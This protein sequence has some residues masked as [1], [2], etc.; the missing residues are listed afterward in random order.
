MINMKL[1]K[2]EKIYRNAAPYRLPETAKQPALGSVYVVMSKSVEDTL[3][4]LAQPMFKHRYLTSYYHEKLYN[5]KIFN[6]LIRHRHKDLELSQKFE[7][8]YAGILPGL[9]IKLNRAQLRAR[10]YIEDISEFNSTF[11]NHK[12]S[13]I[14]IQVVNEYF[15]LFE[16]LVIKR[17]E[18][19]YVNKVL[20][21]PVNQ[22]VK[23]THDQQLYNIRDV[24]NF[25]SIFFNKLKA[26]PA[27]FKSTFNDWK[28]IFMYGDQFFLLNPIEFTEKTFEVFKFL[29]MK[30]HPIGVKVDHTDE[31]VNDH[32]E[33]RNRTAI[34]DTIKD[35]DFNDH[36]DDEV[37]DTLVN[38]SIDKMGEDI[39]NSDIEIN[40]NSVINGKELELERAM[41]E[42]NQTVPKS[43][44]RAAREL[45]L[46]QEMGNI[47]IDGITIS[48]IQARAKAN[49][50]DTLKIP[51]D[52]INPAMKEMTFPNFDK[53]Y[54]ENHYQTDIVNMM[55][56]LQYKDR[57]LYLI[58]ASIKDVS[59]PL[60]KLE[61]HTYVFEDEQGRRHNFSI[62]LPKFDNHRFLKIGGNKRI[63]INQII[64][65]PITKTGPATVQIATNYKKSFITRFGANVSPKV[66]AFH[67]K[68]A[69]VFNSKLTV[70]LGSVK[71]NRGFMTTIEYDELAGRYR[72]IKLPNLEI[73]FSQVDI[74][75]K[76]GELKLPVPEK[77]ATSIPIGIKGNKEVIYLNTVNNLVEGTNLSLIDYIIKS[78]SE[79]ENGFESKFAN[80]G[81]GKKYMYSRA[82]I[83]ERRVPIVLLL[84]Y[85]EGLINL[86]KRANVEYRIISKADSKIT[87]KFDSGVE[88]VVEFEDAW[89][90]YSI[91]PLRN[92]LLMN[93]LMEV[94]TKIYPIERFL[95]KD[96]YFEIFDTLFGRANIG[97][98]F[99]NF[100]QLFIDPITEEVLKDYGL[101]TNFIDVFLYANALLEDNH[102]TDEGDMNMHRIR[103]NEMVAAF[104]YQTLAK[105]YEGY[106]LTADYPNPNKLSAPK[107]AVIKSILTSQVTKDYSDLNP[108]YTID[109]MRS[110]TF[111]GPAGMNE[112]RSFNLPKRSFHPSMVGI[113]SQA[114]P[115]SGSIG[116]A[117]TL[118]VD[119]NVISSR[120]YMNVT[121][122]P[123]D[124]N[125]L[126]STQLTS[127]A[128]AALVFST[129]SDE[130]ERVAM[131]SAQSRHTLACVGSQRNLVYGG[132]EKVLPHVI[133]DTFVFKAKK[134]GKVIKHDTKNNLL[135]VR[136]DDNTTDVVNLNPTIGKNSGSGFF[137]SNKLDPVVQEGEVF[138][139]G[140]LL[141]HNP[142]FFVKDKRTGDSVFC[143][144]PLARVALRYSSKVFE[145]STIISKRLSDKLTSEIVDKR[146]I[147]I[148]GNS[149]I[150]K[151]VE[152]GQEIKVNDPLI[153]FDT[154]HDD[155]LTNKIL[156]KLDDESLE[157]IEEVSKTN[158][159]SKR[160]GFIEDI[161]IFYTCDKSELSPSIRAIIEKYEKDNER[162]LKDVAKLTG[163][164]TTD[165]DVTLTEVERI[166]VDGTGKVKG[167]K[168]GPKGLLIE[169]YIK[170]KDVF[171]VGDKLASFIAT[172]AIAC[173]VWEEGQEPYLLSDPDDKVDAYLGVISISARMT[174]SIIKQ[175]QIQSVLIGMKKH[176]RSKAEKIYGRSMQERKPD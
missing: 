57:P 136:Y 71:G 40:K 132:F 27:Y 25:V 17:I 18:P 58:N 125:K 81:K 31:E 24:S 161:K 22:W 51:V 14:G 9:H 54:L 150:S 114:S 166:E 90:I 35:S 65:L 85:L 118:T 55:T 128:E 149:N 120:G 135:V 69:S 102:Y 139:E 82:L 26:D 99:E 170:Y 108:L 56:S 158:V 97:R 151:I 68:L 23:D 130:P 19:E 174:F 21:V 2:S 45:K 95:S 143:H 49:K 112:D 46:V 74:R 172:K 63:M 76:M 80:L 115:I 109:L 167:A 11:F 94:P 38:K 141:A 101:P 75:G 91:Y 53:S 103:S 119:A 164:K 171:S 153:I 131:A 133:G 87:P 144:G 66:T 48:E 7:K 12:D 140:K 86:M 142:S 36:I 124:A 47:Q 77:T 122:T 176:I 123:E 105:A 28:F 39:T 72:M 165:I 83:M 32:N 13:R 110:T 100:E 93:G 1:V 169:I 137:L 160:N 117:R 173:D 92:L 163:Q 30:F 10:N 37:L 106:R 33:V 78:I 96:V 79:V 121:P 15:R 147:I 62:N 50:I 162:K 156:A 155:D 44:A 127:G 168:V 29:M 152:K 3:K 159:Y 146:D 145:D 8:N 6:T 157:D 129:T 138:T 113:L 4:F 104:L 175:G 5:Y 67:G 98:A 43:R 116:I 16:E 59:D 60:N 70:E 134:D 73:N 84:A 64:P 42:L 111:K 89:L 154:S 107:D 52:S 20:I 126:K 41:A 61:E 148:G 88:D 34:A